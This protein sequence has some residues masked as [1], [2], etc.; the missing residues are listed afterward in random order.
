MLASMKASGYSGY[1]GLSRYM[2]VPAVG[3][4]VCDPSLVAP[5]GN[6]FPTFKAALAAALAAG[7]GIDLILRGDVTAEA[8]A[9][10]RTGVRIV[11]A[12]VTTPTLTIPD[13]A[14]F[15]AKDGEHVFTN[16]NLSYGGS[17][18]VISV[19][20]ENGLITLG[21][22]ATLNCTNTATAGILHCN[23]GTTFLNCIYANTLAGSAGHQVIRLSGGA[24]LLVTIGNV[25][26]L[27]SNSITGGGDGAVV[28]ADLSVP[29]PR[30][31]A[32]T[33]SQF[34]AGLINPQ[35]G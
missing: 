35:F 25:C 5:S 23:G 6:E 13:G 26:S 20:S 32:A 21:P 34:Q 18:P 24:L 2:N 3:A 9:F 1:M 27:N 31:G 29:S 19:G 33:I 8:E 4:V 10:D 11:G 7:P 30:F 16:V 12:G 28:V 15:V 22:Y 17:G 14:T